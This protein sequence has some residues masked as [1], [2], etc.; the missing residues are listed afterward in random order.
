MSDTELRKIFA[1][2]LNYYLS[3][4]G[5]SQADMARHMHVSTAT[6]AQWCTGEDNA[7]NR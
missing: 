6:A 7:Q 1:N 2:N 3:I 5:F 4:N